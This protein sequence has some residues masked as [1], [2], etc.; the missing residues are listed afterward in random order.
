MQAVN[1]GSY[2]LIF[3]FK[4]GENAILSLSR[5]EKLLHE[6]PDG[7]EFWDCSKYSK[8]FRERAAEELQQGNESYLYTYDC[9]CPYSKTWINAQVVTCEA[10]ED[11]TFVDFD[12]LEKY[13]SDYAKA[14]EE[15]NQPLIQEMLVASIHSMGA[16]IKT[17]AQ[18][19]EMGIAGRSGYILPDLEQR[20]TELKFTLD[21]LQA[22]EPSVLNERRY[23][24]LKLKNREK[25]EPSSI[26]RL[27]ERLEELKR[28]ESR[29]RDLI[30]D[31][32]NT[33]SENAAKNL[34]IVS[35]I[36]VT[37]LDFTA[38][39]K[40]IEEGSDYINAGI[41][42]ECLGVNSDEE[43]YKTLGKLIEVGILTR[44]IHYHTNN[45]DEFGYQEDLTLTEERYMEY[46]KPEPERGE[47]GCPLTGE[48]ITK[49][50]FD[51]NIYFTY[52]TTAKYAEAVAPFFC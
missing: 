51:T 47:Y 42:F 2:R 10:Y 36:D 13:M 20:F 28:E 23:S 32:R 24:A 46:C 3:E 21:N 44:S 40:R 30:K 31:V 14:H 15:I 33:Q 48:V 52:S 37:E 25:C 50:E 41:V 5:A 43:F 29:I 22:V 7:A 45:D 16:Y 26:K 17:S 49:E 9:W 39:V 4:F 11:Q 6:K 1:N 18:A 12:Q 27:N 19:L 35:G 8:N 38:F 34:Q